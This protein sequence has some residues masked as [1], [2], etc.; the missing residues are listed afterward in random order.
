MF[1]KFR[2]NKKSPKPLH[3]VYIEL[4]SHQKVADFTNIC[5]SIPDKV[6]L[7]GV[8]ENGEEW[9]SNAKSLLLN[10]AIAGAINNKE[11]VEKAKNVGKVNWNT[12]YVESE[13]DIYNVLKDFAK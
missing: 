11:R 3:K 9:Y 1:N 13:A 4:D 7:R 2:K 10:L 6:I 8:D 5:N 12:V